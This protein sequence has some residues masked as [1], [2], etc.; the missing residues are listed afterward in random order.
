MAIAANTGWWL[1]KLNIQYQWQ[2]N[3]SNAIKRTATNLK[4]AVENRWGQQNRTKEPNN[5]ISQLISSKKCKKRKRKRKKRVQEK[6]G[7]CKELA[8]FL[9]R[10]VVGVGVGF[11]RKSSIYNRQ[12]AILN[13]Q[14]CLCHRLEFNSSFSS[15]VT[16][17][18]ARLLAN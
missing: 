5:F 12:F 9:L 14:S 13:L 7:K 18:Y 17:K 16:V 6:I 2:G 4:R 8:S 1:R 3:E 11:L 10:V 15:L